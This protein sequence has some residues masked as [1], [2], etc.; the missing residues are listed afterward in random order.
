MFNYVALRPKRPQGLTYYCRRRP[1]RGA[2]H[3]H[4]DF[5]AALLSHYKPTDYQLGTGSPAGRP[6]R[7]SRIFMFRIDRTD[8]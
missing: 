3:V 1:G 2:Q 4:L 8:Y 7:R 6:P 5:H